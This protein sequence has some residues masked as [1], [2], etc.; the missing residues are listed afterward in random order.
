[1]LLFTFTS[2]MI[3]NSSYF[4]INYDWKGRTRKIPENSKN[5]SICWLLKYSCISA[6]DMWNVLQCSPGLGTN[7]TYNL[8]AI[9]NVFLNIVNHGM[10]VHTTESLMSLNLLNYSLACCHHKILHSHL[11]S[12]TQT[13]RSRWSEKSLNILRR[14]FSAPDFG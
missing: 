10:L 13:P 3:S 2:E 5:K 11:L 9:F 1:M 14:F 4:Q 8:Y 6:S 12:R 7:I